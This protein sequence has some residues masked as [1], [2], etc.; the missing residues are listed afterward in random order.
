MGISNCKIERKYL[1]WKST[2]CTITIVIRIIPRFIV[3]HYNQYQV[4]HLQV[5]EEC[6]REGPL[7]V[8]E[9]PV[10]MTEPLYSW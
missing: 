4:W 2:D 9:N 7:T 8:T 1:S 3:K 10:E 6:W 5:M